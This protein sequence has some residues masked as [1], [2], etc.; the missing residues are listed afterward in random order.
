[1]TVQTPL[2]ID[3]PRVPRARLGRGQAKDNYRVSWRITIIMAVASLAVLIPIYFAVTMAL[4]TPDQTSGAGF[5]FPFPMHFENFKTAWEIVDTGRALVISAFVSVISVLGEIMLS[6]IAAWAIVRNFDKKFFRYSFF[7]ILAAMFIPFPVV[8]LP[9]IKLMALLH[10]DNPLGVAI[11]HILF[12][13][14]FNILLY[15]AYIR[16]IPME[17]EE[18]ARMDGCTTLGTFRRVVLP[19][20]APMNATVGIFAFLQSWN[21]FMMPSLITS[22]PRLQTLPVVQQLFTSQLATISLNVAF[23]S[24]LMAMLPTLIGYVIGQRWVIAGVMRGA[25]K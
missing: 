13:L 14:S 7:Y 25:V 18:S 19:L 8:A 9:Q 12:S 4:K 2:P 22:N 6:S 11:L 17:L 3:A 21:D 1:M 16:S 24:Y 10:L 23:A 5:S 15:S 20:L